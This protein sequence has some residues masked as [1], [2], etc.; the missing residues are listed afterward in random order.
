MTPPQHCTLGSWLVVSCVQEKFFSSR[1]L[2]A[3]GKGFMARKGAAAAAAYTC[4]YLMTY[5]FVYEELHYLSWQYMVLYSNCLWPCRRKTRIFSSLHTM[6]QWERFWLWVVDSDTFPLQPAL[7]CPY[8]GRSSL[9]HVRLSGENNQEIHLYTVCV[10]WGIPFLIG[11]GGCSWFPGAIV[12]DPTE[13]D[14]N[15]RR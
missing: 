6:S 8:T 12:P 4:T 10:C 11:A 13:P 14:W 9:L 1:V 15:R 5:V 3:V 7:G 2:H